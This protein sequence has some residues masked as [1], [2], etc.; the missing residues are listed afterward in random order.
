MVEVLKALPALIWSLLAAA[1]LWLCR[2]RIT[3]AIDR[4]TSFE[5]FG[6]KVSLSE[7][8]RARQ[9]RAPGSAPQGANAAIARERLRTERKRLDGAEILWVDDRPSGNR[10]EMHMFAALGARITVAASTQ[11]AEGVVRRAAFHLIISDIGRGDRA[12]AGIDMLNDLRRDGVKVPVVLYTATA[13]QPPP[14]GAAAVVD[15]P[16]DLV[17]VVLDALGYRS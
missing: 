17:L 14:Q 7:Y 11:E 3:D 12:T 5:G 10:H 9:S 1:M 13:R 16:D 2:A 8:D 4:L 6:V 15:Q